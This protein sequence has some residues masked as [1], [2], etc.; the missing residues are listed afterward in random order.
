MKILSDLLNGCPLMKEAA[1]GTASGAW[2]LHGDEYYLTNEAVRICRELT[3]ASFR[4]LN[5]QSLKSPS[6]DDVFFACEALPFFDRLRVVVAEQPDSEVLKQLLAGIGRIPDTSLLLIVYPKCLYESPSKKSAVLKGF[7]SA[8]RAAEFRP[9]S[10]TIA[11]RFLKEA[12]KDAGFSFAENGAETL[13]SLRGTGLFGLLQSVKSLAAYA[14]GGKRITPTDVRTCVSPSPEYKIFDLLMLFLTG[15]MKEGLIQWETLLLDGESPMGA[16]MYFEK[17]LRDLITCRTLLK[18]GK[19]ADVIA[20][21]VGCSP[22]A[23]SFLMRD[24]KACSDAGLR[25]ALLAFSKVDAGIKSGLLSDR[26]AFTVA[27]WEAFG[28]EITPQRKSPV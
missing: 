8:G 2:L 4:E 10:E 20:G 28:P 11:V 7:E 17:R 9:V 24:A 18:R 26:N 16:L 22:S 23:A 5:T 27:L 1:A 12:A 25:R 14:S 19:G 6:A 13:V 21:A 15:R 3:D